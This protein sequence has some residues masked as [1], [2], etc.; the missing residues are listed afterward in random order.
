VIVFVHNKKQICVR[1][2]TFVRGDRRLLFVLYALS[3]HRVLRSSMSMGSTAVY[4]SGGGS[5]MRPSAVHSLPTELL[6]YIFELVTHA[7]SQAERDTLG[8]GQR[9]IPFH[10]NS[11]R[12][13]ISL[14]AVSRRWRCV[15]LST[16]A[17][18]TSL[19]V[20]L[21]NVIACSSS[22]LGPR[23]TILDAESLAYFLIRSRNCT[24]DIFIDGRDPEWDFS[25]HL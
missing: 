1:T 12:A 6:S 8:V 15:A 10:P 20:S 25:D 22:F 21:D 17:L 9:R 5:G 14:S 24:L 13:P 2:K 11:I 23:R 7:L 18:W 3:M 19:F 16:S 4:L